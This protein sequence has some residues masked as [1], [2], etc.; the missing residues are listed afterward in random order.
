MEKKG[1]L[2]FLIKN[3]D[4]RYLWIGQV[5][6]QLGD[7]INW[8]ASLGFVAITAPG[9]GASFLLIWLMIPIV[10]VGPFAGVMVDRFSRKATMLLSDVLRAVFVLLFII[11]TISYVTVRNQESGFIYKDGSFEEN[12][13][14]IQELISKKSV[15]LDKELISVE[16]KKSSSSE[17]IISLQ[18]KIYLEEEIEVSLVTEGEDY[19]KITLKKSGTSYKGSI[20]T[21][22]NTRVLKKN[23]KLDL[24][25]GE[26]VKLNFTQKNG[27]IYIAY[28][29]TFFISLITQFF[30]PAKSAII[31]EIVDKGDLVYANSLSASA[32]RVVIIIGGALGGFLMARY[33]LITALVFDM[34]TTILSFITLLFVREKRHLSL[35]EIKT[36]QGEDDKKGK[37][38]MQELKEAY[39]YIIKMPVVVFVVLSYLIVMITG[40]ISYIF[41]IKYSNETL[42]MGV[43]GL[44]YLQTSLG[45]GVILG[46]LLIGIIGNRAGKTFQIKVGIVVIAVSAVMFGFADN[47]KFAVLTGIIAGV[48]ASFIIIISETILQIV[49]KS[50]FRGRIFGI[51]QTITNAA[52]AVSAIVA[53]FITGLIEEKRLFITV[54][55]VLII[56]LIINEILQIKKNIFSREGLK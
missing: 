12:G 48:G 52:F 2:E 9:I 32:G 15:E 35:S 18:K 24:R 29:V 43:E 17:I 3:R 26:E 41:L 21:G 16:L 40:G 44:G 37:S 13:T 50:H 54:A 23:G 31:P 11:V 49:V 6:S 39:N 4:F 20:K 8:M 38:I 45:V 25:N 33:G 42:R 36:L 51:L 30:V 34:A 46:S 22:E 14:V 47:I 7:A 53:G 27:P 5:I 28:I 1:G 55:F 19:E 56:F 10:T